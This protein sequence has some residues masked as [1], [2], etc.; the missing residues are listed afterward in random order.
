M[1]SL[2]ATDVQLL[3]M[4]YGGMTGS[5]ARSNT[6]ELGLGPMGRLQVKHDHVVEMLA[7]LVLTTEDEQLVPPP[8]A[9]GMACPG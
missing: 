9:S 5:A 1:A 6:V 2:S 3:V 8:Q 4:N 7:M